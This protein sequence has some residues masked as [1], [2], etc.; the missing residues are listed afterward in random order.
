MKPPVF[1]IG[2]PRSGTTLLRLALACHPGLV[3]PPECGFAVWWKKRYGGWAGGGEAGDALLETFVRDLMTSRKIETWKIDGEEVLAFLR[4]R[5]PASYPEAVS[6]VYEH[7][8]IRHRGGCPRWGDKNNFHVLHVRDL[9]ELF[10]DASFIHIVR[11]GRDVA[12]SYRELAGRDLQDPFAPHL[13]SVVE[14]IAAD[15]RRGL[16]AARDAFSARAWEGVHEIRFE[17]LVLDMENTLRGLCGAI[18]EPWDPAMLCYAEENREHELEPRAFL[19]WK[20]KTLLPPDLSVVGRFRRDLTDEER[21]R[22]EA[23]AGAELRLYAYPG[24]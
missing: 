8:G 22:F 20:E 19:A 3:V 9:Q 1:V 16:L 11:D 7:Y 2:N 24:A 4:E 5:R 13:P 6:A 23:V 18:G 17:D 15:W 14:E 10:P 12:C 21:K